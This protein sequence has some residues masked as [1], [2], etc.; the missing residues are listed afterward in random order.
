MTLALALPTLMACAQDPSPTPTPDPLAGVPVQVLDQQQVTIGNHTITYNRI[1]PPV[2][3]AP[4][5]SAGPTANAVNHGPQTHS[6]SSSPHANDADGSGEK[7]YKVLLLSATVYDHQF[8]ALRFY[9]GGSPELSAYVNIDFNY[10]RGTDQIETADTI[11]MMMFGMGDDAVS[12]LTQAG[13]QPPNLAAFPA[14]R[15][16]YQITAGDTTAHAD[17]LAA[18]DT[19]CAYYDANSAQMIT[20]YNQQQANNAAYQQ[21]L[22]T[23]PPVQPNTVINYWPTKNSVFLNPAH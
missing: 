6:A 12:S 11:Y 3:P 15:S 4:A 19:L 20:T 9:G 13:Q 1:A 18:L 22:Q 17:D 14:G 23:H 16:S 5:P 8:T 10:F 2:F 7:P 21:W